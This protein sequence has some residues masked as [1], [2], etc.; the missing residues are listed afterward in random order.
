MKKSL[1]FLRKLKANNT[2]AWMQAHK[3]EYLAARKEFEALVQELLIRLSQRDAKFEHMEPKD[4]MFRLNRDVR[5]SDNKKPYKENFAAFFGLGGKKGHLPGYY[6]HVSPKEIFA[7][8]GVWHPEPDKL[9]RIQRHIANTGDELRALVQAKPFRRTFA[10]L[11]EEHT[12]VRVPKGFDRDH[13]FAEFLK[14]KSIIAS[15][16]LT[17][18]DALAKNFGKKIDDVFAT[19]KPLNDYLAEALS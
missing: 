3:E 8:G 7:G 1:S 12:L 11:S 9:L 17:T 6:V 14:L 15:K 4:C 13:E 19:L 5:F 10:G 16:D 18:Q 2:S